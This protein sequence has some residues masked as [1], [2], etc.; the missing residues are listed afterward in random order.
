MRQRFAALIALALLVSPSPA[1][2]PAQEVTKPSLASAQKGIDW[3]LAIQNRDG[4]WG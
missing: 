3:L 1:E 2:D 4:S